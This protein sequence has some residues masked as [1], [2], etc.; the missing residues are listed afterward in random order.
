M[1]PASFGA[2]GVKQHFLSQLDPPRALPAQTKQLSAGTRGRGS[3]CRSSR[4]RGLGRGGTVSE[5][6]GLKHTFDVVTVPATREGVPKISQLKG[7]HAI[8]ISK[9]VT[10]CVAN[11][12][13][14][15]TVSSTEAV[16]FQHIL[17]NDFTPTIY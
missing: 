13:H 9:A 7:L 4:G 14:E 1:L 11:D 12:V 3:A 16:H 10:G 15:V 17:V 6:R 8:C 2:C 5:T